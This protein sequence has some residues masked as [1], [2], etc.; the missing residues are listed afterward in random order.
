MDFF[1]LHKRL[2]GILAA[3]IVV[4]L[5]WF[6][7][8]ILIG[9]TGSII[10]QAGLL[11]DARKRHGDLIQRYASLQERNADYALQSDL[12][13]LHPDLQSARTRL[14]TEVALTTTSAE[15]A[16]LSVLQ[17]DI[18]EEQTDPSLSGLRGTFT[19]AGSP[20][21]CAGFITDLAR[22]SL[23]VDNL[24]LSA[25]QTGTCTVTLTLRHYSLRQAAEG[26]DAI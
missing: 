2:H 5:A 10:T 13:N 7:F 1:Q 17:F 11:T 9:T 25:T 19:A 8:S 12:H 3:F 21:A 23:R 22:K 6:L 20:Q 24:Q 14:D 18:N 15:T 26:T 4:I 16:G